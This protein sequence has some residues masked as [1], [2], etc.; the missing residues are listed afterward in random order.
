MGMDQGCSGYSCGR[1]TGRT[2]FAGASDAMAP[3]SCLSELQDTQR[4]VG[5]GVTHVSTTNK[6]FSLKEVRKLENRLY[7]CGMFQGW[8]SP[9]RL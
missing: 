8:T 4:L 3:I 1:G 2:E 7:E 6:F 9:A 5:L